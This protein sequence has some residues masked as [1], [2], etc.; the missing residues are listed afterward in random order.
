MSLANE[1][2]IIPEDKTQV[3]V[4]EIVKVMM[5]DWNEEVNL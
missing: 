3:K 1:L 2:A 5:L 4:G